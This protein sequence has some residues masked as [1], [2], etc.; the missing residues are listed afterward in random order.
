VLKTLSFL[1]LFFQFFFSFT[2][3]DTATRIRSE[4]RCL[5][6]EFVDSD[7]GIAAAKD[8]MQKPDLKKQV[9]PIQVHPE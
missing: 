2:G 1:K 5:P 8:L 4:F 3:D 6:D 7:N 9:N